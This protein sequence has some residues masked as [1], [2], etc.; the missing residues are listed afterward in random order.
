MGRV[1]R[2]GMR[3]VERDGVARAERG[4]VARV[5]RRGMRR[6]ERGGMGRVPSDTCHLLHGA[7]YSLLSMKSA[8]LRAAASHS[9]RGR[10]QCGYG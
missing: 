4:G 10:R 5:E 7:Y 6:V 8:H 9:P 1:E 2:G 3:R